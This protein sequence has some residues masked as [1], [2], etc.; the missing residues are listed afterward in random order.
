M[1]AAIGATISTSRAPAITRDRTSR[2]SWSV[3]IQLVAF[4]RRNGWNSG[5]NGGYGVIRSPPI[6]HT[7]QTSRMSTPTM[8]PGRR[9]SSFQRSRRAWRRS[10][11]M[12]IGAAPAST[13]S[14]SSSNAASSAATSTVAAADDGSG[15]GTF[16]LMFAPPPAGPAGSSRR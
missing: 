2:P 6:A 7:I 12:S 14:P 13:S 10:A 16:M 5:T 9:S 15:G 1:T 8:K 3:P 4:G 11:R